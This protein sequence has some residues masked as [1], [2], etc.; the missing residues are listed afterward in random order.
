MDY[1]ALALT[2]VCI[3]YLIYAIIKPDKF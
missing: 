2:V 1:L 3:V